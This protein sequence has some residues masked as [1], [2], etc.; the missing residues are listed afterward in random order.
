MYYGENPVSIS[1]LLT[2]DNQRDK[3]LTPEKEERL[4]ACS[5][6]HLMPILITALNTGMRKGEILSLKWSYVDFENNMLIID[7]LNNKSKRVKRISIN[8]VLSTMLRELKLK[9]QKLSDYVLLG[10]DDKPI[11]DVKTAFLNACRRANIHRLRFHDL[12]HTA[13]THMVESGVGIVAISKILGHS[14][15]EITMKRY[16]HPEDSLRDAAE[17]LAI[18]NETCSKNCSSEKDS[19]P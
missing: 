7:A 17:K 15:V 13:G 8:K 16:L 4:L 18:F 1:G 14:N 2:E 5:A 10:D 3:V 9:N 12:R 19:S 11:K 6:E